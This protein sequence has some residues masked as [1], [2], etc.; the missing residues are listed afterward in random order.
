[1]IH[2]VLGG[3]R[4]GKSRFAE[5]LAGELAD[6]SKTQVTYVAT[7]TAADGEMAQR[8]EQHRKQRPQHWHLIEE[9]LYLDQIFDRALD[10]GGNEGVGGVVLIDCMTLWLS[11]W[12]CSYSDEAYL[13]QRD[14]FIHVLQG[15]EGDCIIV[16]N[17]VGSGIV[18][19]GELS[20]RFADQ[21]G[22]L[23]QALAK[24]SDNTTLV[25]AGLPLVLK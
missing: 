8:I 2:L 19:M 6:D 17:E 7:A 3:A 10:G 16:S 5:R 23:N 22:W 13:Q 14:D 21:A 12:L 20:R 15:F 11:N 1:M 24:V 18:P 4:S 9:T 25:V